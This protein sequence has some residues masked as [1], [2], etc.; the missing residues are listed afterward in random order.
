LN[1]LATMDLLVDGEQGRADFLGAIGQLDVQTS[2]QR[3]D[4]LIARQIEGRLSEAERDELR[5]LMAS[6]P[7]HRRKQ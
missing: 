3:L 6:K 2:Q 5:Q 4:D 1:K 7:A